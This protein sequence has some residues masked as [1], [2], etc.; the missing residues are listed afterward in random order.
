[1]KTTKYMICLFVLL[2][3]GNVIADFTITFEEF[4]G[5]DEAIGWFFPGFHFWEAITG[6][7]WIA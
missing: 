1:M 6:Q 4:V 3:S 7:D 2:V 5:H